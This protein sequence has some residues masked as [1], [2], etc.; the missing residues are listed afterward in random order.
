MSDWNASQYLKFKK[1]RT[2]PAKDLAR[3]VKEYQPK[4]IID[5]G[6]GPGNS[7][8]TLAEIF[9]DADIMGIDNSENMI[10]KAKEEHP[11]LKFELRDISK[12]TGKYD[13]L[14]SNACL[15]WVPNH[16]DLL[17]KLMKNLSDKGVLAIQ[18]PINEEE[19][20]FKTID[21]IARED[22]WGLKNICLPQNK[23]LSPSRYFNILTDCSSDFDIWETKYYH[24]L[25]NHRAMIEWVKGTRLRPYLDALGEETG[26][27]FENEIEN[28]AKKIYP[29]QKN[30]NIIFG[31]RRLFFIAKK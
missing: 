4:T 11:E 27:E 14:F 30:G 3:R 24:T 18:I 22:R 25:E 12:I 23:A 8:S 28:K 5:I 19:P 6:C 10:K 2:Q 9:P 16:D 15:Q 7:T 29:P 26:K 20:L 13:L 21:E 1:Q 17:P 31:F